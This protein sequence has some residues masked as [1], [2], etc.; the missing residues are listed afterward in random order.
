MSNNTPQSIAEILA[1]LPPEQRAII[2]ASLK[3]T[4]QAK[5]FQHVSYADYYD[6]VTVEGRETRRPSGI[7]N[8]NNLK[9]SYTKKLG[10]RNTGF[11]INRQRDSSY[12]LNSLARL[13]RVSQ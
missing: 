2:E 1:N 6:V 4:A 12:T 3:R 8:P 9:I 7:E 5:G 13:L 10:R 11:G